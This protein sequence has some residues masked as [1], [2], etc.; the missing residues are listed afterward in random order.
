MEHY[1]IMPRP[2]SKDEFLTAVRN[3]PQSG[4]PRNAAGS[5][6]GLTCGPV[7][8]L[9]FFLVFFPLGSVI[10]VCVICDEWNFAARGKTVVGTVV[11]EKASWTVYKYYIRRNGTVA[12]RYSVDGKEYAGTVGTGWANYPA[13]S[14]IELLVS[15]DHPGKVSSPDLRPR[16]PNALAL[17]SLS[18][19]WPSN[20]PAADPNS[21]RYG[22]RWYRYLM[23]TFVAVFCGVMAALMGFVTIRVFATR[24]AGVSPVTEATANQSGHRCTR[25]L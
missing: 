23:P 24:I 17:R 18:S 3:Y 21:V 20:W 16:D 4:S 6:P 8:G 12:V 19:Q 7:F 1:P 9:V 25:R 13:G 14:E 2:V 10:G 15:P 22:S 11:A 5:A